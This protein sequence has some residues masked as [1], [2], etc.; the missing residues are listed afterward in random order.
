MYII[1]GDDKLSIVDQ[2]YMV[3]PLDIIQVAVDQDPINSYCVIEQVPLEEMPAAERWKSLHVNLIKNYQLKN[4]EFCEQAI[5]YLV[6]K[7]H[8]ELDSFYTDLLSR[9]N[10]NKQ[11]PLD[12]NWSPVIKKF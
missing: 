7:W 1:L 3:V 8:G 12:S 10:Q 4:W 9:V 6:G 5:E 2:R 11:L